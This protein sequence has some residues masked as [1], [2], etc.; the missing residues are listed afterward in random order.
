M[1]YVRVTPY[2]LKANSDTPYAKR[3]ESNIILGLEETDLIQLVKPVDKAGAPVIDYPINNTTWHNKDF[4]LMVTLSEDPNYEDLTPE[5]KQNYE[6]TNMQVEI[7]TA[8]NTKAIY[9]YSNT[10]V[11]VPKVYS[12]CFSSTLKGHR[13]KKMIWLNKVPDDVLTSTQYRIRVRVQVGNYNGMYTEA[14]MRDDSDDG[15]TWSEWSDQIILNVLLIF[16]N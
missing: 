5:Q 11:S 1:N 12:D 15:I 7:V 9:N 14:D 16:L 3:D 13:S 10:Y 2:Y 4:R 8:D 6:Y